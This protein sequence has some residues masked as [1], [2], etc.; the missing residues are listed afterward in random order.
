MIEV[1]PRS[2]AERGARGVCG[3]VECSRS[4]VERVEWRSPLFEGARCYV[5]SCFTLMT[6]ES[7]L[8]FKK[9][10]ASLQKHIHCVLIW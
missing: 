9:V 7:K 2:D 8:L 5:V 6:H 4:S 10:K 1:G 3:T